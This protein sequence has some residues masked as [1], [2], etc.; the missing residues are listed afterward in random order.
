MDVREELHEALD[1]EDF[2]SRALLAQMV[3]QLDRPA[4]RRRFGWPAPLAAG[5]IA[6]ALMATLLVGRIHGAVPELP[7]NRPSIQLSPTITGLVSYHWVSSQVAW[8]NLSSPGGGTVIA[9]TVDAG[10]TWHKEL[11][12]TGLRVTPTAQFFND[13][14]GVVIGEPLPST[15]G[16]PFVTAWR[17][18]NGGANWQ[19]YQLVVDQTQVPNVSPGNWV[20]ASSYFLDSERGWVLL[21]ALYMCSGCMRQDNSGL[22]LQTTDGGAHWSKLATLAY[23]GGNWLGIKFATPTTGLVWTYSGPLYVT[24]DGGRSWSEVTLTVP[25]DPVYPELVLP[26]PPA[27]ISQNEAL[28]ALD[29][30]KLVKVPCL[31]TSGHNEPLAANV[32]PYCQ[33]PNYVIVATARY[34]YASHDGGI[35]W[36]SSPQIPIKGELTNRNPQPQVEFIDRTHWVVLDSDGLTETTDAGTTWSTPRTLPTPARWYLSDGQFLNA[37]RGWVSVSDTANGSYVTA[38]KPNLFPVPWPKFAMLA[39]SDGGITWQKVSLPQA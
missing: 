1:Q 32:P 29:V 36:D 12:L 22:V 14:E 25:G 34:V 33:N 15:H 4:V 6:V 35:T 19:E 38:Q 3:A 10:R 18:S 20:V 39:T 24:H 37:S 21:N 17:T 8:L 28:M 30:A 23:R 16:W 31:D 7:D 5:L 26:E 27:F 11:S 9:R 2:P 13:R